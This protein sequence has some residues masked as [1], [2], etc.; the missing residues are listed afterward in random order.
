MKHSSILNNKFVL[1]EL[2]TF[3]TIKLTIFPLTKTKTMESTMKRTL[4]TILILLSS[5][6]HADFFDAQENYQNENFLAA[7][8]EYLTL[9]KLG[10]YQSQYN[11]A[12][13]LTKGQGVE[14]NLVEAYAWAKT[15][16]PGNEKYKE[17][18]AIISNILSNEDLDSAEKLS[19]SFIE[20]YGYVN[21]KVLIGPVIT[22]Q[23]NEEDV[24]QVKLIS[25]SK[26]P[27]M[28]PRA[29]LVKG[30]EGWVDI[31]YN[32][33][34]DGSV[35]D[36]HIIDDMPKDA[37]AVAALR[38]VEPY[39]YT[40]EKNGVKTTIDEPISA[41]TRIFFKLASSVK[42][43]P[44]ALSPKQKSQISELSQKAKEGDLDARYSYAVLFETFL[45]QKGEIPAEQI[46]EWLF[47][48]A[49]N[50]VIDAQYRLG[51]NIYYGKACKVEKQKG[52]DWIM[53][54]AQLGDAN[55]EYMAYQMLQNKSVI[56]QSEQT[57]IYWLRQAAEN[58][59][60]IA[61]MRLAKEISLM[62][63]PSQDELKLAS[64]YLKSYAKSLYKTIQWHQTNALLQ[65]KM[66]NHKK[67]LSSI[68]TALKKAAKVGWNLDELNQQKEMILQSK[69]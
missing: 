59:S 32:V 4:I 37:F 68:K 11:A 19:N 3:H 6:S 9:S 42:A 48:L 54:A 39:T 23:E 44:G 33:Y 34:P 25:T 45:R 62:E 38:S 57:P 63:H 15:S 61:Q 46:N 12:V 10:N 47:N 58:G 18:T 53:N 69:V 21:A 66:N 35:R 60:S 41:M 29:Q 52:V 17:L 14:K 51:K 64:S 67:A 1:T 50:G 24:N 8:T 13:M 27:P 43:D 55:A 7:Y 36:I 22:A 31:M 20:K 49:Q 16:E 28:Y 5:T 56:N 26:T 65:H 40:F 30:M 2:F